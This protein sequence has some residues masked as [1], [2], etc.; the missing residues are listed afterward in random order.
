MNS[1]KA[2][3]E[4]YEYKNLYGPNVSQFEGDMTKGEEEVHEMQS[5]IAASSGKRKKSTMDKYFV[6]RNTQG[7]QPSIR[8]VLARKEAI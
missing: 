2:T 6:P 7:A 4:A 5:P 8:S 1:K 3:Q